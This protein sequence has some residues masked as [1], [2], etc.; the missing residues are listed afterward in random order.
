[1]RT[2]TRRKANTFAILVRGHNPTASV[3]VSC[4]FFLRLFILV[5]RGLRG[6]TLSCCIS[7]PSR[8]ENVEHTPPPQCRVSI[9]TASLESHIAEVNGT[10]SR[11]FMEFLF[12]R[13]NVLTRLFRQFRE[14]PRPP[15]SHTSE[16]GRLAT[17][18]L[19]TQHAT[20][21]TH[22]S[23]W[24]VRRFPAT[25]DKSRIPRFCSARQC[26]FRSSGIKTK[27]CRQPHAHRFQ[28][29]I[30]Q[31]TSFAIRKQQQLTSLIG[32]KLTTTQWRRPNVTAERKVQ[33][34]RAAAYARCSS[35][36]ARS[37]RSRSS[38]S[39]CSEADSR[40]RMGFPRWPDS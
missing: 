25:L 27:Q 29:P 32:G 1:M 10:R 3:S 19:C 37:P 15:C 14:Q 23:H 9:F 17:K 6:T 8:L 35:N 33:S 38:R 28:Q 4:V 11:T 12:Q 13:R 21:S 24:T 40:F 7:Q 18:K 26:G 30:Y 34:E 20:I 36:Y 22:P 31:P 16:P 2:A 5:W 39:Y